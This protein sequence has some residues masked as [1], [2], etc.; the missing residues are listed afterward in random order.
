MSAG[1]RRRDWF[2]ACPGNRGGIRVSHGSLHGFSQR[3]SQVYLALFA[4]L[5]LAAA[6]HLVRGGSPSV[7][8]KVPALSLPASAPRTQAAT[9]NVPEKTKHDV[10]DAY[11]KLPLAF[12]QNRGQTDRSVRY[13]AQGPGRAFY[14]TPEKAVLT[15]TNKEK[16]VALNLTPLGASPSTRLVASGRA[17]G[18]VNYL[19]GSEHHRSLPAYR[20]L[21]YRNVWPGVDLVFRGQGGTL[22]YEL[23]VRAGAD[24]SKIQ[25]AYA[26]ADG[27]SVGRGG[28][29]LID[30]PLGTLRDAHPHSYQRIGGKHVP[31]DSRYAVKSHGS[32]YGFALGSSYEPRHPLVIDP[33]IEYST[34]LGGPGS[35]RAD[36]VAV[37]AAG[38]AYITGRANS[39]FPATPGAF[40]TSSNGPGSGGDAYVTKL[41]AS[42]SALEYSTYVGGATAGDSGLAIAIDG[43]GSAYITGSTSSTDFPTTPAAYDT[44]YNGSGGSDAFVA[45]LSPDGSALDYST[46]LG[47]SNSSGFFDLGSGIA[48]DGTGAAYIAGEADSA[49]F[50]VTPGAFDTTDNGGAD[51]FVT[52]LAPTGSSLAYST[53]LGGASFDSATALAVDG[54]G[55]AYIAGYGTSTDYPT[56]AGA[57]DQSYNQGWDV[58]VTK[59]DAS[60]ASLAY[61]TYLGGATYD[62]ARGI[63]V[64][65][66]GGAY[67]TGHTF[68]SDY[69]TTAGAFDTSYDNSVGGSDAFVTK[70]DG[71]GGAL[72]YS[73]FLGGSGDDLGEGI[74]V[75]AAGRAYVTGYTETTNFPTVQATDTSYN[76]GSFDVFVTKLGAAGG[77][78]DFSTYLGGSSDDR[79][80]G[81]AADG[82]TG[83]VYVAGQTDSSGFPATAGATDTSYN[84][85]FDAFVT[86]LP[87]VGSSLTRAEEPVV[88]QQS[89]PDQTGY[90]SGSINAALPDRLLGIAPGDL[91]AFR[92][93]GAWK[94]VPVQVDE[95]E[96]MDLNR[97]YTT[98]RPTCSDPCYSNPPDGGAIHPEFTDP[99][100]FVGPDSDP[101]LDANDEV[102]LMASDAGGPRTTSYAPAGVDPASAVEVEV[103]DP[104]DGGN[105]Y[106]YLFKDRS[107]LDPAAG[108]DYV[109]Y[110]F[111]LTN[112][113]YKTG[114]YNPTGPTAGG[115]MNRGP[116]PE[117]SSVQT[118]NYRRGFTD[119]WYDNELRVLRGGATGVDILDRHDDQ[120]DTA[121]ASCVRDQQTFSIGE[122]AFIVNKDG[123]V[124]AIRDFVGANSGP[125]VQRQHIFYSDVEVINTF[126]RVHPI[127]GVID[128]FDYSA[129]GS[130]LTY[131]NGVMTPTGLVSG[132][133]PGGVPIDGQP[134]VV[135]GA[136]SS[137]MDGFES[138]DGPQGGL[139]MPQRLLTNNPDPSYHIS[140]RDGNVTNQALCTGD[141]N[142][143]YGASGP[144]LNSAVDNTDEANKL[145][146]GGGQFVN[147]FYQRNIYY[148]APGQADGGKRLA[149]MEAPVDL[150]LQ[151]VT[152][153]EPTGTIV[154]RKD[155]VPDDPQDFDFTAGG[156]LSPASFRL[157]D[158]A[159]PALSNTRTFTNVATGSG[160]SI[161]EAAMPAG[162]EQTGAS[163]DDGSSPSNI[164]VSGGETVTCTFTNSRASGYPRPK[165]ATP[166]RVSLVPAFAACTGANR[167]HGAPLASP[168]CNPP[169]QSSDHLTVGTFDANGNS[170][171]SIGSLRADVIAGDPSPS[172]DEADVALAFSLSDIRNKSDLLDY[173]GELQGRAVVRITDRGNGA[174]S[175][176]GTVADFPY[177]FTVPC[178]A[179]ADT[180]V[181][182][183]CSIATTADTL[184]PGAIE[185]GNRSI[186]EFGQVEVFD[187]GADGLASTNGDNTP[188]AR[189]GL[190]V[191]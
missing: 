6:G 13:Y 187:G 93:D 184:V 105:G 104:I 55:N 60:G 92:W 132:T 175:A 102:A 11:G 109:H 127:P 169:S 126:L 35:D 23:H 75:D 152:M 57:F 149:E 20:E 190:F 9:S 32:S 176:A 90:A 94:Q 173:T 107:G 108:K 131:Q 129:A 164:T 12:V 72:S 42:G 86:R 121:D 95:R 155:A 89:L 103:S 133:P 17:P 151:G 59:L 178:S 8:G 24:L 31:V 163:C 137:L 150:T 46:Y 124:R 99:G 97:P 111:N 30:T 4:L 81:I 118:G 172:A 123:P 58:F 120:F 83:R 153:S 74:A 188:F 162:W 43:A 33:G 174:G 115:G 76:G 161:A 181:G 191:P 82:A 29:L 38:S 7:S 179:T 159:D 160:Y 50:P 112:G 146:Y 101:T 143:L 28:N 128:F 170:A 49:N 88:I 77:S 156:G 25:L 138:V 91:V 144:Q 147:V 167:T 71:S 51:A 135:G 56:T 145:T 180:T 69:P 85:G 186:W 110:D 18:K 48:V 98:A 40:D 63:T 62:E 166:L 22:K 64:D 154:V 41:N 148:E 134:D 5:A 15:F 158:D 1:G 168:S 116:R 14:F 171:N 142:Q 70:L 125:H 183:T 84:G 67:V 45:K 44:S 73:T 26:G 189:Q 54:S 165:G 19:I 79:G 66:A 106:V 3:G 96:V 80:Y 52:K 139:S 136:G 65:G 34:F 10:A 130:G 177:A 36:G 2:I 185:E 27:V 47:G 122:G 119:R 21:A 78:L 16:G 39:G 100:T 182:S 157:D 117:T 61:S 68:S 37:D 140:Y 87:P 114:A 141:D 113:P 53:L